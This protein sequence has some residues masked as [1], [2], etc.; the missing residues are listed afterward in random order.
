MKYLKVTPINDFA[1][2]RVKKDI[3]KVPL[4]ESIEICDEVH[5]T[6]EVRAEMPEIKKVET[7]IL[8]IE[9]GLFIGHDNKKYT[10][11]GGSNVPLEKYPELRLHCRDIRT[12]WNFEAIPVGA[13]IEVE[14]D[15]GTRFY[16]LYEKIDRSSL[17]FS[18][19]QHVLLDSIQSIRIIEMT[20]K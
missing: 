15:I 19:N 10:F 17:F 5:G 3:E 11:H 1:A 6:L 12:R 20:R 2:D 4:I 7:G 16:G 9:A 14:L 13:T 8:D 18:P